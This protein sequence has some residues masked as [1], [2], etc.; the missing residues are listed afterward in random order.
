VVESE[1]WQK[2]PRGFTGCS[3]SYL[4]ERHHADRESPPNAPPP[5]LEEAHPGPDRERAVAVV[6]VRHVL[7]SLTVRWLAGASRR[8][9]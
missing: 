8:K 6:E 9:L 4:S 7:E 2:W 3:K 5:N 1:I